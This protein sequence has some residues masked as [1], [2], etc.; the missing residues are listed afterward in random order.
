M[1]R[2]D[3]AQRRGDGAGAGGEGGDLVL[4]PEPERREHLVVPRAPEVDPPAGLADARREPALERRVHILVGE[5]D[6]PEALLVLGGERRE[7]GFDRREVGCRQE[8]LV[9]QHRGVR[10]RRPDVVNDQ[11]IVEQRVLAGG[12]GEHLLVERLALV[13]E[14][15]HV[16]LRIRLRDLDQQTVRRTP[17]RRRSPARSTNSSG[18]CERSL[19]PGPTLTAG[20]PRKKV[21]SESV[22]EP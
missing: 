1:L 2:R 5:L 18:R 17:P 16:A 14:T 15:A 4:H 10:D 12:V 11:A 6:P 20:M 3:L 19:C 9:A 7:P 22:A 21:R 13:P 8:P